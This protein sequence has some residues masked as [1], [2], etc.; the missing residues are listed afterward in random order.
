MHNWFLAKVKCLREDHEGS[1][2]KFT[3]QFLIDALSFTEAEAKVH[4]MVQDQVRGEFE[5]SG[6][7]KSNIHEVFQYAQD[8]QWYKGKVEFTMVDADSGKSRKFNQFML[9]SATNLRD[10]HDRLHDNLQTMLANPRIVQIQETQ[11]LE[12]VW[13]EKISVDVVESEQ[14]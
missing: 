4:T 14:N 11:I 1:I 5:V 12:V 13:N 3:D 2:R 9:V 7:S 8:E 6:L 10:A